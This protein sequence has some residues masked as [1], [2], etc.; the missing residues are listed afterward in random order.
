[1]NAV[2]N[3][4]LDSNNKPARVC[5]E[6]NMASEKLRVEVQCPPSAIEPNLA[7]D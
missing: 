2:W 7:V 4:W 1:M 5:V 3:S 6:A